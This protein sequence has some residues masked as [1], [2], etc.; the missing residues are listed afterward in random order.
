M[1]RR[2]I[3]SVAAVLAIVAMIVAACAPA[4]PEVVVETVEV[5]KVVTEVVEVE[6]PVEPTRPAGETIRIGGVGPLSAPGAVVGGIAMQFA[7]NLAVQDLNE[8]GGVLGKPVEL[9]FADTEGLPER[10]GAVAERLITE[11]GVVAITG[12]YHSAV[13]LVEMEVCHEYGIPCLFSETWSDDITASGYPEVFRIAPASSMNSRASAEWFDAIGVETVVSIM[14][15]TDYGIGQNEKDQ[16]FFEEL[17]IESL[18]VFFVELGTEDYMP[19]LT[20]IQAMDPPPDVIRMA[21]TGESSYNL[22]QQMTELGIAP[23]ADTVGT[24]NQVAIQ[25][26]FWES[27]PNG[28]YFAFP[29]VGLPPSLY[30]DTTNHV[31]E[32][33]KAQF[34]TDPPSYALEAYDSIMILADA[35][36]R[37]GTTEPEV[38]IDAL[39]DTDI[40]LAQGR[41]YFEYTSKNPLPDDG[42]VSAYMWHQWPDPAVLMLQYFES[43]QD[44]KEAAVVWPEVYQTH[45]TALIEYEEKAPAAAAPVVEGDTIRIGGVGPL[46]APGTVV[47]GIAMQFA[48]NLAVQDINAA[49]GVLGKPIELIFA[50]TEGLPERGGAVAERLI[51]EN[52]VVAIT[53]EYH[54]AVGLVELEVC[55]E[56]G[57]PC[58][59]SETWSDDITASGYPEVFRIAPASS[60]NSRA[61]ADWYAAVGVENPVIIAENTDYGIGQ[62]ESDMSFM[63]EMGIS[64]DEDRV[65]YVELGTEDYLPIL[66]R[67]QA[68]D[69]PPDAIRVAVT[70]ESSYNLEQQMT[71]LGLAPTEE[72]IG[73]ANQVAIQPEFWESVPNG[74]YY[75]FSL[76]GLPPSLYNDITTRVA[77]AYK[78]QFE[79]DPPS[80]ALEAYDSLWILA[81]AI[82]RAGTT[83][84]GAVLDALEDTDINLAQGRYWFQYTSDNPLPDDGSVPAYMW[85]QW[86]DPA[87]LLIQY[88]EPNQDWKDAAVIWPEVYQTHG[89]TYIVPGTTP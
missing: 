73:T 49:G 82:E 22:A 65:F 57:I 14:E 63:E 71:E 68:M 81:D 58:L 67:I 35:M 7:M 16:Q 76:V 77:D 5:E 84:P 26:E 61:M 44:W 79:S 25:P 75:V 32:A 23:S 20:R 9:I 62:A 59:F 4:E 6:V 27:V 33:Y 45:G 1:S 41:Y 69:P 3:L 39:E 51:T 13:G 31:A 43:G 15:N 85:H 66:T 11:N 18:E 30:N 54:S 80:Y 64:I 47:G 88:F 56:Y 12:E 2:T 70:G 55:H 46:S 34:D 37:A 36:E 29:L 87:V 21:V 19:I 28:A 53:G 74:N 83:Q 8:A 17:G 86:P 72:T 60:M 40:E 78:E 38:L 42:S 52:N 48:M 89:T 10:G 24:T 50:D